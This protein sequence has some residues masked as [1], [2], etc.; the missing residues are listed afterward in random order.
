MSRGKIM[1][2]GGGLAI[3]GAFGAENIGAIGVDGASNDGANLLCA[4]AGLTV[5]D[6][7]HH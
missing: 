7:A 2:G 5:L 3:V 4:R 1:A 6:N